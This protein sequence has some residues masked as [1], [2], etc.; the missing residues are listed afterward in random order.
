MFIENA[1]FQLWNGSLS[2]LVP[3]RNEAP[4]AALNRVTVLQDLKP[5]AVGMAIAAYLY[6]YLA[7]E[8]EANPGQ[9]YYSP[10]PISF[11]HV[12]KF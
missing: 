12:P 5:G 1:G 4:L 8:T 7:Y 3:F 2:S 11:H 10:E 6:V 9:I